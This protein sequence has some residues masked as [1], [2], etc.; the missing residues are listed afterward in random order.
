MRDRPLRLYLQADGVRKPGKDV[1][2]GRWRNDAGP[3]A[4]PARAR[5]LNPGGCFWK[6]LRGAQRQSAHFS[7][8]GRNSAAGHRF[9]YKAENPIVPMASELS[10]R[11]QGSVTPNRLVTAYAARSR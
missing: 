3:I 11:F 4:A 7:D 6:W 8:R 5:W 10:W 1:G 9:H 2:S